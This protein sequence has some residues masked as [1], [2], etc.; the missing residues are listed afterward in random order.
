MRSRG[1]V[2]LFIALVLVDIHAVYE[3]WGLIVA[4]G[5]KPFE[6]YR[7][8]AAIGALVV[9]IIVDIALVGGTAWVGRRLGVTRWVRRGRRVSP[10]TWKDF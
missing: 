10:P 2:V 4:N 7:H 6:R 8:H 9:V 1:L 5:I 3:L